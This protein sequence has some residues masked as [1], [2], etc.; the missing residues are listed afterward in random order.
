MTQNI[1]SPSSIPELTYYG[2]EG[3]MAGIY[4]VHAEMCG[5]DSQPDPPRPV[6]ACLSLDC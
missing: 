1:T 2:N 5:S 6:L 3:N 4:T